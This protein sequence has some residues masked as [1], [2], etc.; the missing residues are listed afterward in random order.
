MCFLLIVFCSINMEVG[1]F[2]RQEASISELRFFQLNHMDTKG[3][4]DIGGQNR[5]GVLGSRSDLFVI[6]DNPKF[7][8]F[9]NRQMLVCLR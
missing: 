9:C 2:G 1:C 6:S 8:K 4:K 3:I 5:Q 7:L